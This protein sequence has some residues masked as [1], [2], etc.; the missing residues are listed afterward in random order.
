MKKNVTSKES[1]L[2]ELHFDKAEY[3]VFDFETTGTS[4]RIDK[5]IEIGIVKIRKGKIVDTFQSYINPGRQIPYFITTMTGITNADVENAPYFE[6][7]YSGIKDFIGESILVAHNLSFDHSFLKH[8]CLNADLQMLGNP[9]ICTLK[10]AKRLYPQLSSRSLGNL[11]RTLRIR[12]RNVHSGLGDATATA[13]ILL[14][15]F[16]T[17]KE[18]HEIETTADLVNFQNIPSGRQYKLIKKKLADDYVKVPDD[19]GIYFYKNAKDEIIYIGKAKSLKQ[20][21]G[22]YFLSHT[23]RK[24]REIVRKA[25][26][27]GY[28]VTNT[29][30]TALLSEAELIKEMK[31]RLNTLLKKYS[32][33]YFIRITNN[34]SFPTVETTTQ[35]N[36][37]GNDYYG[38]YPNRD[39]T[40][41]IKNIID[42]TFQL[43]ECTDSEFTKGKRCYLADIERCYAPCVDNR[44]SSVYKDELVKVCDFLSG[45][46]QSAVDR[47]LNRMKELSLEQKF[48]E[49]ALVRDTINLIFKQLNKASILSE[50]INKAN[51]LIEIL[52]GKKNDYL[53]LL[54]GKIF[55]KDFFT[56]KENSFDE[57]LECYFNGAIQILKELTAKDLER[58]KISL[59]WLVKNKTRIKVHYL[60]DYNSIDMLATN[61]LF[62]RNEAKNYAELE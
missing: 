62:L 29:E 49:A 40:A 60:R 36:F 37:D 44:V 51:V 17:L 10:L 48:E 28:Q 61:L 50:P 7:V 34:H 24:T 39:T 52:G 38:P 9:G 11:T 1:R 21:I 42:R 45:Q 16:K 47:L 57:A 5:V 22:S 2:K 33:N 19:P 41:I 12:H 30:L 26:S 53:L 27:L 18:E 8:E 31:P 15:M 35:F 54:E 20:R 56:D 13:K 58:L 32:N 46:N 4:A 23:P 43:R 25:D 6:E 3:S 59:S 55:I 14:H